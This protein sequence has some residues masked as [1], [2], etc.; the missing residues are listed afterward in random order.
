MVAGALVPDRPVPRRLRRRGRSPGSST[1]CSSTPTRTTPGT[2]NIF[3]TNP[4]IKKPVWNLVTEIIATFALVL[5]LLVNPY[6]ASPAI[7]AAAAAVVVGHRPGRSAGRPA[8]PSTRPVTSGRASPTRSCRSAA[9]ASPDWGYAV[10]AGGRPAD[11]RR[12]SPRS[13]RSSPR[14]RDLIRGR[15]DHAAALPTVRPDS[16]GAARMTQ[17]VAAIDQ[18][19]TSTR[20]MIFDHAGSGRRGRP[21]RA[22]SRSSPRRGGSSTTPQEIWANTRQVCGG[23]LARADLDALLDRR[24]R[25]HQPARDH[26]RLGPRHRRADPQRHRLAGHAHPGHLR[27]A[28]RPRRRRRALPRED[29]PARWPPTSPGRRRAGSSTTSTAPASGPSAASSRSGRWTPGCS[30]TRPAAPTAG[31]TSPTRPTPR[32]PC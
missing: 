9:R 14:H 25:H 23:A 27:R 6:G 15:P 3:S 31:C 17:Y 30:G 2:L 32:A 12:R 5:F 10:G 13:S 1:S 4:P 20:C 16:P 8:T 19:T 7:Y 22:P 26:R 18:G 11:R 24:G 21:A 29:G 28:R